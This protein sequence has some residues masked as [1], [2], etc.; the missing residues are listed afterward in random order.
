MTVCA[1]KLPYCTHAI[2]CLPMGLVMNIPPGQS[3]DA[4][5]PLNGKLIYLSPAS[6]SNQSH[7]GL[8][9]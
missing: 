6:G 5:D 2:N 1:I 3:L 7:A 4:T 9:Y 8:T